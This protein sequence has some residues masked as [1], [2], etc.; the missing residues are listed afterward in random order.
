MSKYS[1]NSILYNLS[2]FDTSVTFLISRH[3][4]NVLIFY[5]CGQR[6]L[7]TQFLLGRQIIYQLILYPQFTVIFYRKLQ[8]LYTSFFRRTTSIMT[9]RSIISYGANYKTHW[10]GSFCNRKSS[11]T[12]TFNENWNK[13][14][15]TVSYII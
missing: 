10:F 5:I 14:Y 1:L 8:F 15:I 12:Y 2:C 11:F 13:A 3:P 4:L 9:N 6:D 7:N